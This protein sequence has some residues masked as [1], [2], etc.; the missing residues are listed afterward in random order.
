MKVKILKEKKNKLEFLL[1][2]ASP[3]FANAIRR[4][5]VSGL[6]AFAIDE[7]R[8][9]ENTSPIF[10]EYIAHRIGLIPLTYAKSAPDYEVNFSLSATGPTTVYSKDLKSSDSSIKVAIKDIPIIV[11]AK[12]Q[13][14][15][16]TAVARKGIP[17]KHAKFQSAFA[18]YGALADITIGDNCDK[19]MKCVEICPKNLFNKNLQI[20]KIEECDLCG[21]C[22]EICPKKAL[23]VKP[24][25]GSF[26]FKVES[27]NN[28]TAREQLLRATKLIRDNAK[29]LYEKI[30]KI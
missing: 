21:A 26:I 13:T 24:S 8:F 17:K 22:M 20:K 14:L 7:V 1:T 2:D 5:I 6:E 10:N 12:K 9:S 29:Q 3:A 25:G 4:T 18:S 16:L 23:I 30:G 28:L 11:L 15:R 27:Y 19:C